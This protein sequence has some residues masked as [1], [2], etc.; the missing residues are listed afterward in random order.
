V[1]APADHQAVGR[2]H[3]GGH[4]VGGE[5]PGADR[6]GVTQP[7]PQGRVIAQPSQLEGQGLHV[8]HGGEQAVHLVGDHLGRPA[9]V[10]GHHRAAGG[11][12]LDHRLSE[13]LGHHRGVY[14]HVHAGQLTA[15]VVGVADELHP[16]GDAQL[17]AQQ[18]EVVEEFVLTE[19]RGA[20]QAARAALPAG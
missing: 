18:P 16:L 13:W 20:H 3:F 14:G 5:A 15:D 9:T 12:G 10:A 8:T 6:G 7:G 4:Q 17:D 1:P 2:L 19:Q 11:H